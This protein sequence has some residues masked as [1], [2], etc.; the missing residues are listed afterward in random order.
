MELDLPKDIQ[1]GL[2][3]KSKEANISTETAAILILSEYVRI[4]GSAIYAGT[5]RR[6]DRKGKKGMRYVIDW[7]FQPGLVKISGDQSIDL[8]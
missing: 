5:W 6:G 3:E 4:S 2:E 7:P 8:D 1:K